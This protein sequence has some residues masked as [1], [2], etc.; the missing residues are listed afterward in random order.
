MVMVILL[1]R[2]IAMIPIPM[3]IL[4]L[5][6]SVMMALTTTVMVMMT[7]TTMNAAL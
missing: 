1:T 3:S 5:M 4:G 7:A 6:K 2:V